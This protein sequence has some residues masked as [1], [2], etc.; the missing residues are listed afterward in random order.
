MGKRIHTSFIYRTTF[1][2]LQDGVENRDWAYEGNHISNS[3]S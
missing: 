2:T 1:L 3:D